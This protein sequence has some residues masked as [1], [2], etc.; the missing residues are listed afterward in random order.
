MA[1][2]ESHDWGR[3]MCKCRRLRETIRFR[4]VVVESS[5]GFL[6]VCSEVMRM[7]SI[8]LVRWGML[9]WERGSKRITALEWV[10]SRREVES[11][12]GRIA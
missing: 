7:L 5:S 6:F 11:E 3:K 9:K 12:V 2:R 10:G 4:S 1:R 8:T